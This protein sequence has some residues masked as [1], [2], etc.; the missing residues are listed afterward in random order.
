MTET[1][2]IPTDHWARRHSRPPIVDGVESPSLPRLTKRT[3]T[4]TT[5][6]QG[7]SSSL[8]QECRVAAVRGSSEDLGFWTFPSLSRCLAAPAFFSRRSLSARHPMATR[9]FHHRR[10]CT[11]TPPPAGRLDQGDDCAAAISVQHS[12]ILHEDVAQ[13]RPAQ[14]AVNGIP[15]TPAWLTVAQVAQRLHVSSDTVRG[16]VASGELRAT[17]VTASGQRQRHHFRI[18]E[19]DLQRFIDNREFQ[20]LRPQPVQARS[21]RLARLANEQAPHKDYFPDA[22]S[23]PERN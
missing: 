2:A 5:A 9:R 22:P 23:S 15:H 7:K 21:H 14:A 10:D 18:T 11:S 19:A 20:P 6:A 4:K 1:A 12:R 3:S 13:H 16:W 17:D 8:V